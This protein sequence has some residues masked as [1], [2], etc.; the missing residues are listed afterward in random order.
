[1]GI[2][3]E[4]VQAITC[5]AND[6]SVKYQEKIGVTNCNTHVTEQT[7][8]ETEMNSKDSTKVNTVHNH[9]YFCNKTLKQYSNLYWKDIEENNNYYGITDESLCLLCKLNHYE[10]CAKSTKLPNILTDKIHSRF[11][12]RY[13]KKIGLDPWLNSETF[14]SS[15]IKKTNN[16]LSQDCVIKISRFLEEK[17]IIHKTVY[18]CF[19]FLFYTNS[20]IWHQDIF[21]YTDSEAKCS[22]YKE[23]HTHLGIWAV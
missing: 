11:C 15:Q 4:K 12:K 10:E 19:P 13:K 2:G 18:K 23:V 17:S 14:K 6:S 5:S 20:N 8:P 7:L 9:A 1:M 21:K 3:V 22:I 16:Y